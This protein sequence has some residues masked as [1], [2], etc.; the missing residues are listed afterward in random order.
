MASKAERRWALW[1]GLA[2]MLITTIPYITGF[3]VQNT[4]WRYSGLVL[5]EE[6]GY[7]YFAKMLYGAMGGW[8]FKTP[9]TLAAQQG[10]LGF[11]PYIL[12]GKLTSPPGQH[13]QIVVLFHLF[14]I[15]GGILVCLAAYDFAS[16]FVSE[17][18][19]RRIATII[20]MLGGGLGVLSILGLAGLWQGPMPLEFY[21]PET[22]GFLGL[23]A[24]PHLAWARALLLWG[25]VFYLTGESWRGASFAG[26]AWLVMGFFQ[27]LVVVVGWVILGAHNLGIFIWS[28]RTKPDD[29]TERSRWF[30]RS[31]VVGAISSPVVLYNFLSFRFDPFLNLWQKQNY[32]PSPPVTD[33]ILAYAILLPFVVLG[34]IKIWKSLNPQSILLVAWI[35]AFPLLAYLPYNLQRRLPEG[36][37]VAL[38]ILAVIGLAGLTERIRNLSVVWLAIGFLPSLILLVIA[39]Q[40]ASTIARPSFR[41]TAELAAFGYFSAHPKENPAVI[42]AYDT[43]TALPAYAPVRVP[44]GH[45]PE[46]LGLNDLRPRVEEIYNSNLADTDRLAILDDLKVDYVFW[47]PLERALGNAN[48]E[49]SKFLTPVFQK[50]DYT[51]YR[52]EHNLDR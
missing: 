44:I 12:L 43:S 1:F 15:S 13:E 30:K 7:S 48:L 40:S 10:F 24:I 3:F 47:G 6:D 50:D 27:P 33:Y 4:E 35:F 14:R 41:P 37:W 19:W 20:A 32:L 18:R 2:I 36:L 9:Y 52:V 29:W 45:G 8:L 42:A 25:L 31:L 17:I 11:L 51:I 49:N 23:L 16:I 38:S 26:A 39:F 34:L 22:F 21:S 46:S 5:A 28:L